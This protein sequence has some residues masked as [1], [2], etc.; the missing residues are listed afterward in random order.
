[1]DAAA[2]LE[3]L[4]GVARGHDLVLLSSRR[5]LRT[6]LRRGEVRRLARD[7]YALPTADEARVAAA[8]VHG[9]VSHLS[10]AA[11]HGWQLHRQPGRPQVC[12]PRGRRTSAVRR[13]G[14]DLRWLRLGPG[15]VQDGVTTPARTVL[16]CARDLSLE[17][18][19]AV[20]DSALR[21]RLVTPAQLDASARLVRGPGARAVRRVV[22]VADARAENAFESALRAHAI[23]AGTPNGPPS[24]GAAHPRRGGRAPRG[25]VS[26]SGGGL[27]PQTTP[28][29]VI[30]SA[31]CRKLEMLAPKT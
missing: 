27:P 11:A 30:A 6:A 19:L 22:G 5:K 14:M 20:A 3:Q 16:D 4:G 23:D 18:A 8:R 24:P 17:E 12:V 1:M 28:S 25:G 10:A 9:Y 7:R 21:S 31:T 13:E 15:D 2:A 29:A 26:A